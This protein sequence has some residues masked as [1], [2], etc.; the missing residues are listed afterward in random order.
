[1]KEGVVTG[2]GRKEEG[3]HGDTEGTECKGKCINWLRLLLRTTYAENCSGKGVGPIFVDTKIGRIPPYCHSLANL[4][5]LRV[6][7]VS[8]SFPFAG[9][10][11]FILG[12]LP[13]CKKSI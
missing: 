9:I 10:A 1:M 11:W 8:L 13:F 2:G 7:V 4:R 6:S 5:G 12:G 3:H